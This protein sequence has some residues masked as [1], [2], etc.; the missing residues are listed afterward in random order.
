LDYKGLEYRPLAPLEVREMEVINDSFSAFEREIV[1][2]DEKDLT[3]F[4]KAV[5]SQ[6]MLMTRHVYS[7]QSKKDEPFGCVNRREPARV[8]LEPKERSK[9]SFSAT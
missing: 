9:P 1:E 3:T 8:T 7:L 5:N 6:I 2:L 4:V